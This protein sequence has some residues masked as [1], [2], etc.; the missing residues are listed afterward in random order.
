MKNDLVVQ[1]DIHRV[2]TKWEGKMHF[3][4][5]VNDHTIHMDKKLKHGGDDFGPRPKPLILS[6]IGG[7]TGMEIISILE[8]MRL[9]IEGLEVDVTAELTDTQPKMYKT[10]HI[11]FML[12]CRNTDRV[13]IERAVSLAVDKYC[14]VVA[15][16]RQ[17]A[18]LTT[19]INF[20]DS[21]ISE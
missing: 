11:I 7:C 6:A 5:D 1:K 20:E 21:S 4:S 8:K 13:K 2:L 15:M 10:V 18:I 9:S 19:E 16:V 17:F 14:G 12:R 3:R